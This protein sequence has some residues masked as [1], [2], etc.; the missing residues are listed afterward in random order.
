M[1]ELALIRIEEEYDMQHILLPVE[2]DYIYTRQIEIVGY[3]NADITY[4]S[5]DHT[6]L[7]KY[8]QRATLN[9]QYAQ[10]DR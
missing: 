4:N 8:T 3:S 9:G 2:I 1:R 6:I 10:I 7:P 5:Q